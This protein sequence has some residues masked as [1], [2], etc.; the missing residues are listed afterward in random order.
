MLLKT[1]NM[2]SIYAT[3][4]II[5]ESREERK[6]KKVYALKL[7]QFQPK[8]FLRFFFLL[9]A[10]SDFIIMKVEISLS[11]RKI[12]KKKKESKNG[13]YLLS[14]LL[15]IFCMDEKTLNFENLKIFFFL[16]CFSF[17]QLCRKKHAPLLL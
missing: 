12:K 15:E 2:R 8:S 17:V 10:I 11:G 6:K 16:V 13:Q 1:T 7:P 3:F 5:N 9:F 4:D 14:I